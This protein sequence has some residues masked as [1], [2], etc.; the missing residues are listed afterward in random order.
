MVLVGFLKVLLN[1]RKLS[2]NMCRWW[3]L[4]HGDELKRGADQANPFISKTLFFNGIT[5]IS[6]RYM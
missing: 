5:L 2:P 1:E 6:T 3:L 4:V